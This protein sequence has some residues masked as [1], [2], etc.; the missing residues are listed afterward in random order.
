MIEAKVIIN[1]GIRNFDFGIMTSKSEIE[2][3]NAEMPT[4]LS[5]TYTRYGI[6][7][8]NTAD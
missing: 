8:S 4:T 1:F 2:H 3:P 5:A 7:S 6:L